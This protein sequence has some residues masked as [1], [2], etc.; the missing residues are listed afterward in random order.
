MAWF[1][2]FVFVIGLVIAITLIMSI[3]R[4]VPWVLTSNTK[5]EDF[6]HTWEAFFKGWLKWIPLSLPFNAIV[7]GLAALEHGLGGFEGG[8][9]WTTIIFPFC[10]SLLF[11]PKK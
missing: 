5:K 1:E 7:S 6:L 8:M 2:M 9:V 3:Y 11:L 10:F 4:F